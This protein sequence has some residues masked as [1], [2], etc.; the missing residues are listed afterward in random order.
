MNMKPDIACVHARV[1]VLLASHHT[2]SAFRIVFQTESGVLLSSFAPSLGA[3]DMVTVLLLE[4]VGLGAKRAVLVR[5][6]RGLLRS[7][8]IDRDILRSRQDKNSLPACECMCCCFVSRI[9]PCAMKQTAQQ[10]SR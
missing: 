4:V 1:L 7:E 5:R 10:T 6:R 3:A 9:S 2:S 8:A